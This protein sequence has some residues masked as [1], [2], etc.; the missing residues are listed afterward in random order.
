MGPG[1]RARKTDSRWPTAGRGRVWMIGRHSPIEIR[2]LTF[3][4]FWN[5]RTD[6]RLHYT[7]SRNHK[8]KSMNKT[9]IWPMEASLK[10]VRGSEGLGRKSTQRQSRVGESPRER[11]NRPPARIWSWNGS[12]TSRPGPGG[13]SCP[14][15]FH[16]NFL[17]DFPTT[18]PP[19]SEA[20]PLHLL[21]GLLLT[22]RSFG[23]CPRP[24]KKI[25]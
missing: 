13:T 7:D 25:N 2:S 16:S 8:E 9:L 20:H 5:F 17:L 15:P 3:N 6:I 18:P 19:Q 12:Y 1:R 21:V 23:S 10:V 14:H 11:Q 22:C 4:S 24:R